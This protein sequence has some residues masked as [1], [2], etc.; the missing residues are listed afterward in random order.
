MTDNELEKPQEW[1]R[2]TFAAA[3]LGD[4]RRTDRL[5]Q[6]AA[7]LAEKPAASLP[8][9]MRDVS[10]TLAAYRFL[11]TEQVSHE[12]IMQPHWMQTRAMMQEREHVL[13]IAD[14]TQIT[15][16]THTSTTGLGPVGQGERGRGFYVHTVLAVDAQSKEVL[17]CAYQEPWIRQPAPPGETREQRKR[18]ARESQIWERSAQQIGSSVGNNQWIHVG[19][20]GADIFTFW[21]RCRSL[22][23]GFVI[24][25]CQDRLIAPL[26]EE[27]AAVRCLQHLRQRAHRLPAQSAQVLS[28]RAE[29]QRPAREALLQLSWEPVL[30]QPPQH[31]AS[32]EGKELAAWVIRVWEPE[33]P[34]GQKPLEWLLVTTV[35]LSTTEQAWERVNWYRWRWLDEDFH[36]ALK[37]GCQIEG[38]QM[39]SVEALL[40]L[41]GILTPM[42]LRLLLLREMAQTA[43]DTE[44]S[45]VL[46]PQVLQVVAA[47]SKH[48]TSHLSARD[49]W[50]VI[51]SLGGY[52]NRN[53]DGPPGWKTLWRGWIYVQ[54]VL[55]GVH[56]APSLSP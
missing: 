9:A 5:V 13:L 17:G 51:A 11:K 18:R 38:R 23:C 28:L 4:L 52:F 31:G 19:D 56:L 42:A 49:L 32:W 33:P 14:A 27:A 29:H 12:Q 22:G 36:H 47:L 24:R 54:T 41:L 45:Q 26:Q 10:E 34:E 25:V 43:P 37:T 44:A 20:S 40:R 7:A 15:L 21:E 39:R 46:S 48:P 50:R 30:I 55:L 53:G 16:T 2:K 8:E 6:I 3:E 1:A 35:P